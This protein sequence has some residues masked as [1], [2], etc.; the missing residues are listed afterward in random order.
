MWL[1]NNV[2]PNNVVPRV[3]MFSARVSVAWEWEQRFRRMMGTPVSFHVV[4]LK[5]SKSS[6]NFVLSMVPAIIISAQ[7]LST[8]CI[9]PD[10][11]HTA[12]QPSQFCAQALILSASWWSATLAASSTWNLSVAST[13]SAGST[14]L[15]SA[16]WQPA[17]APLSP[18]AFHSASS[19][20][21]SS[22]SW[23]LRPSCGGLRNGG[24]PKTQL[25][26]PLSRLCHLWN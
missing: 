6:L 23:A 1:I 2:C 25:D 12:K 16:M 4:S 26:H 13:C 15:D 21:S 22:S 11:Q 5:G 19:A 9:R 3:Q 14:S 18:T 8:V 10:T 20:T 17:S 24:R 7:G